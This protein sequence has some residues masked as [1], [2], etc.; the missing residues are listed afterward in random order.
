[1]GGRRQ[2][3]ACVG[4]RGLWGGSKRVGGGAGAAWGGWEG[5]GAG[6]GERCGGAGSA[7]V[8]RFG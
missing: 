4:G 6:G 8:A 2:K 5:G 7:L 3:E 1:M